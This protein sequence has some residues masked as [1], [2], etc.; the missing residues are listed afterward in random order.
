[1]KRRMETLAHLRDQCPQGRTVF[2]PP[3]HERQYH[4]A[5]K[6]SYKGLAIQG[7]PPTTSDTQRLS[8]GFNTPTK[9]R[10]LGSQLWDFAAW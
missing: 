7:S 6:S 9:W 10:D 2:H 3:P 8:V 4:S 5:T 1:M